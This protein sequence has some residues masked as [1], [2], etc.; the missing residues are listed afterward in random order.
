MPVP[1]ADGGRPPG[2]SIPEGVRLKAASKGTAGERWLARLP[3][4]VGELEERWSISVGE[5]LTGGSEAYVARATLP[6][7]VP[8]VLKVPLPGVDARAVADTLG[9]ADGR[10]YA[11]LL[12]F[13]PAHGAMLLEKVGPSLAQTGL[14]PEGQLEI[15]GDVLAQAWRVA[16]ASPT[17]GGQRGDKARALGRYVAAAHKRLPTSCSAPVVDAAIVCAKRRSRDFDPAAAVRVHGDA[18]PGNALR[19]ARPGAP[20]GFVLVDPE[21]FAGD[22]RYDLGVA[23]RDF[24]EELLAASDPVALSERYAATLAHRSGLDRRAIW[25]WAYLE[26]VST[27]LYC[28]E[29]GLPQLGRALLSSA[30]LLTPAV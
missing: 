12:A 13:A 3:A 4:V 17:G 23:M 15:L 14:A 8:A 28:L 7:G 10:G 26:R 18:H 16:P 30:A 19:A 27:G 11:R 2:S 29:V 25:E 1:V 21:P 5:V 9:R 20:R 6:G 24:S 22:P